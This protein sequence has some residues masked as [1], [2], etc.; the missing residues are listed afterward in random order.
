[1]EKDFDR[2]SHFA[3]GGMMAKGGEIKIG[4]RY[5]LDSSKELSG[6]E[7]L[8]ANFEKY[9]QVFVDEII[10]NEYVRV[11]GFIGEKG[12]EQYFKIVVKKSSLL[13]L[14]KMEKG[15][16]MAQGGETE[17]AKKVLKKHGFNNINEVKDSYKKG[18]LT[19]IEYTDIIHKYEMTNK[20]YNFDKSG[21]MAQ[22]GELNLGIRKMAQEEGFTPKELG[23]EYELTMAQA[24]VEALTD[25]NYHDAARKLVSLLE[26]NPKI[27]VKP[28]YPSVKDPK[29]KQKMAEIE[30]EYGSKY[31]E[32]DD[33]TRNFAI[34]VSQKSGWDGYAIAGAFEY[35]VRVDGGYHKL[36][37]N[38]QKAMEDDDKMAEGGVTD[39]WKKSRTRKLK[40]KEEAENAIK[41]FAQ[42]MGKVGR[43][44]KVEKM[45]DGYVI[46]YES[47][48]R[49]GMAEGGMT[50]HGLR[51]G[52]KVTTD[53]FWDNQIV[54]ENQKTHKRAQINLETGQR[55]DE[56]ADG[57]ELNDAAAKQ[58]F[59]KGVIDIMAEDFVKKLKTKGISASKK[60]SKNGVFIY[61]EKRENGKYKYETYISYS[62]LPNNEFLEFEESEFLRLHKK[63][64]MGGKVTFEDKVKSIKASLLKTKK[65][66]PK[67]QKDYGKTYSP[68]EA[69][70]SAKRII[71]AQV[72][73]YE[74]KKK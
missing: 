26:K 72:K 13:P 16:Y 66:S 3:D 11:S 18:D 23:K 63:M 40:T 64:A 17:N 30:K 44:Y 45:D 69:E 20:G 37:D 50:E 39:N 53:M 12:K 10:N 52:D 6:G 71:G 61:G 28:D 65:V 22:G 59:N 57:G 43:N 49:N 47:N 14:N 58:A 2:S 54:V 38:I 67:V 55:K 60:S 74:V 33:K 62:E 24:V 15:G 5:I 34:K 4:H 68:K 7:F 32:A 21:Y 73:K 8:P 48:F 31:W 41:L 51:I 19:V 35:L 1:L 25:A 70:Q 29:F 46:S 56:M 36:A 9:K 42:N 27:A